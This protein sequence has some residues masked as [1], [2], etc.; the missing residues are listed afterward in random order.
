MHDQLIVCSTVNIIQMKTCFYP[1]PVKVALDLWRSVLS[2][3]LFVL[4]VVM[5]VQADV[6]RWSVC[7]AEVDVQQRQSSFDSAA[8]SPCWYRE[9][10]GGKGHTRGSHPVCVRV[11]VCVLWWPLFLS[12]KN[13]PQTENTDMVPKLCFGVLWR[14]YE[15]TEAG[16]KMDYKWKNKQKQN[17]YWWIQFG[18][19]LSLM[20]CC[21][22]GFWIVQIPWHC[23]HEIKEQILDE[24]FYHIYL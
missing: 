19:V 11:R 15:K 21:I 3:G 16:G 12:S 1:P 4:V 9:G 17:S 10:S 8:V 20:Y 18:L 14:T 2:F 7:V 6:R 24:C 13:P 5:S 22:Y 23:C